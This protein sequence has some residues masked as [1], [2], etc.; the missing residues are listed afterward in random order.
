MG[1]KMIECKSCGDEFSIK[2]I[3]KGFWNQCDH[4]SQEQEEPPRVLGFNDGSL[5]KS[6]NISLYKGDN[7]QVR[8]SISNQRSRT[9]GF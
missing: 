3:K 4:C 8:K 7:P 1:N 6:T 2:K 5:N 9:G